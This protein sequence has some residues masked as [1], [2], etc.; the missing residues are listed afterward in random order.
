LSGVYTLSGIRR[1]LFSTPV[2]A[3]AIGVKF[4]R[5]DEAVAVVELERWNIGETIYFKLPSFNKYGQAL[6]DM[7]KLEG[8]PFTVQG[9]GLS[10]WAAPSGCS[11]SLSAKMPYA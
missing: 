1:G 2:K 9:L 7:S 5:L 8:I 6:Q 4:M 3:H 10:E 11:I